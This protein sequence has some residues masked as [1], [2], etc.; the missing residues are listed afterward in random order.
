MISLR[1]NLAVNIVGVVW[2]GLLAVSLLPLYVKLLGVHQWGLVA[3]CLAVQ[4][5]LGMLDSGLSAVVPREVAA[6]LGD[7]TR[8]AGRIQVYS[9]LYGMFAITGFLIAQSAAKWLTL[10][11]FELGSLDPKEA[12][13]AIRIVSFQ[14]L[15]QF[16]NSCHIGYWNGNERQSLAVLSQAGF[17]TLKHAGSI[18]GIVLIKPQA[19]VYLFSFSIISAIECGANRYIVLKQLHAVWPKQ[20]PLFANLIKEL[21]E[22]ASLSATV[23]VGVL[24]SSL[25]KIV[26]SRMVDV[27]SFGYYT[28]ASQLANMLVQ[29]QT[30]VVRTFYPRIVAAYSGKQD[31]RVILRKT[32]LA[33][34]ALAIIPSLVLSLFA[35][36]ILLLWTKNSLVSD[37][38]AP[39]LALLGI[40][41]AAN[42]IYNIFYLDLL[43][44]R[45][46]SIALKANVIALSIGIFALPWLVT[47]FGITAGV[48]VWLASSMIGI[49][50][51]LISKVHNS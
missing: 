38:A 8:I 31:V 36:P 51:A 28:V 48:S 3:L 7:E 26:L 39:A 37:N 32:A 18:A 14:F 6:C 33:M 23:L 27:V 35:K 47:Q 42:A 30:P 22:T 11:W 21:R 45:L 16:F 9:W 46:Q 4:T 25:D 10:H 50:L 15:F 44:R 20:R 41:V 17:F 1:K 40:A 13:F 5:T 2:M 49:V 43:A 24:V 29:T 19:E 34:F 12:E